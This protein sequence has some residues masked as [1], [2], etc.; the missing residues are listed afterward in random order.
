MR[1][2]WRGCWSAHVIFSENHYKTSFG[3]NPKYCVKGECGQ[4]CLFILVWT[5]LSSWGKWTRRGWHKFQLSM[6]MNSRVRLSTENLSNNTWTPESNESHYFYLKYSSLDF[7]SFSLILKH[8]FAFLFPKKEWEYFMINSSV[9][10]LLL[11][12]AVGTNVFS[13]YCLYE[14][15]LI[16]DQSI[17]YS[18]VFKPF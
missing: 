1:D 17:L 7:M 15:L 5:A 18:L 9:S 3:G 11:W 13:L 14:Y 8:C 12:H 6:Q 4:P 10:W 2:R 16:N